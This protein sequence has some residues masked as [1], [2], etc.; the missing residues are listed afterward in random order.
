M[1]FSDQ[2]IAAAACPS[3][4]G[5]DE[6]SLEPECACNGGAVPCMTHKRARRSVL[7][8]SFCVKPYTPSRSTLSA[9]SASTSSETTPLTPALYRVLEPTNPAVQ[10]RIELG[11]DVPATVRPPFDDLPLLFNPVSHLDLEDVFSMV[12]HARSAPAQSINV[13]MVGRGL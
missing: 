7:S 5:A 3:C 6:N 8:S 9:D 13:A 4:G 2:L 11:G 1:K 10:R 12:A